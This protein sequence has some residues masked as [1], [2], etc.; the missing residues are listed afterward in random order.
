MQYVFV[1]SLMISVI[2]G[3][4]RYSKTCLFTHSVACIW[5]CTVQMYAL[6]SGIRHPRSTILSHTKTIWLQKFVICWAMRLCI[7]EPT[8]FSFTTKKRGMNIQHSTLSTS[9][10]EVY[11]TER[12]LATVH[13]RCAAHTHK[14]LCAHYQHFHNSL[15][16]ICIL[17][18]FC[19][20]V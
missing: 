8:E 1:N 19:V 14:T 10:R 7:T 20:N 13:V 15:Y 4:L 11:C 3:R 5:T 17:Y 6:C 9:I 12:P 16:S 2:K 18:N